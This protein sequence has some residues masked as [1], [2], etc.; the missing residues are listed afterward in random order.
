MSAFYTDYLFIEL[1]ENLLYRDMYTSRDIK[2]PTLRYISG[3]IS[4]SGCQWPISGYLY[5]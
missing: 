1:G 2:W 5:R 3:N 4:L